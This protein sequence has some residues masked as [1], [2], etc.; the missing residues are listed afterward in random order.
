[1]G[2]ID[3]IQMAMGQFDML[4]QSIS[5]LARTFPGSEQRASE[6]MESLDLWRQEALVMAT[7]QDSSMPGADTMM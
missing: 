3:P 2:G 4:A 7:P 5:D 6:M 1:M